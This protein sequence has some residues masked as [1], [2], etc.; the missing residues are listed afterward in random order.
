MHIIIGFYFLRILKIASH[1]LISDRERSFNVNICDPPYF[2]LRNFRFILLSY[3]YIPTMATAT[4]QMPDLEIGEKSP[5]ISNDDKPMKPM[6]NSVVEKAVAG[7]SVVSFSMSV[8]AMLFERNPVIYIS[9][10]IGAGIAPYAVIQQ[11]KITQVDAL[12]E[13][14]ERG[15][16]RFT[17]LLGPLR[18][19][20]LTLLLLYLLHLTVEE[21]VNQLKE[22]NVKLQG[23]LVDLNKSV[24]K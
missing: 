15:K 11:Q 20:L 9:G 16:K 18:R 10:L 17:T 6:E 3:V 4:V 5:L 19:C 14:N 12:S 2:I 7:A 24:N 22:E 21:E 8:L 1:V 13:S 23:Q